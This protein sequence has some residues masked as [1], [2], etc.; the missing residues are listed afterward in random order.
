MDA[1]QAL[2]AN[3][4]DMRT[5]PKLHD[6]VQDLYTAISLTL[7]N[8]GAYKIAENSNAKLLSRA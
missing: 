4:L 3:I 6:A 8:T 7:S 1:L 5:E 2:G